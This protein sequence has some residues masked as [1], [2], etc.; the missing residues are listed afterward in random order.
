[1]SVKEDGIKGWV[2]K[3]SGEKCIVQIN[4]EKVAKNRRLLVESGKGGGSRR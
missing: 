4:K 1:M 2:E 3:E